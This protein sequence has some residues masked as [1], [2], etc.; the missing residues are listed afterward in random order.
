M[1]LLLAGPAR[2]GTTNTIQTIDLEQLNQI[3]KDGGN[4]FLITVMAAWCHP[5]VKELPDLNKIYNKY[6]KEG[7][8]MIGI[9]VDLEGPKAMQPI[10]DRLHIDFPV[11]WVGEKALEAYSI[12]GIPLLLFVRDG[13]IAD[14]RVMGIRPKKYLDKTIREYLREGKLPDIS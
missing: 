9:S 10:V 14:T 8:Q 11:Y 7:L 6:K 3:I 12:R 2:S 4:H 13:K 1:V 5:C